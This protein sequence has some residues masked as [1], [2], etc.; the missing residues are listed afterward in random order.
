MNGRYFCT[1]ACLGFDARVSR[2]VDRLKG[3]LSG[4]PAYL[5]GV[6]KTLIGYRCPRISLAWDDGV[7]EGPFF[8][9]AAANTATYGGGIRMAPQARPDDGLLGLCLVEPVGFWRAASML[10]RAIRGDHGN[11]PEVR[12]I[13]ARWLSV[14]ADETMEIWADGEPVSRAP[15]EFSACPEALLVIGK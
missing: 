5:Y 10:P 14:V 7:Y 3:P 6:F 13:S 11:L 8:L 4:Q 9:A 15:A 2:C 12:F 1:V